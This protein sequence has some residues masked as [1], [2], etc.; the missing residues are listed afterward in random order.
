TLAGGGS[1]R[2][3]ISCLFLD[4]VDPI[5]GFRLCRL[6]LEAVLLGGGREESAHAVP[7]ARPSSGW[8]PS[9][10]RPPPAQRWRPAPQPRRRFRWYW[11]LPSSL[12]LARSNLDI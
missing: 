6:D 7:W 12:S 8:N 2:T 4:L 11:F 9:S 5:A 1:W 10:R 3:L